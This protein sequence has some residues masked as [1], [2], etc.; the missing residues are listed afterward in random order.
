MARPTKCLDCGA[1]IDW[2]VVR[3]G[4]YWCRACDKAR[5]HRISLGLASLSSRPG[6]ALEKCACVYCKEDDT[7]G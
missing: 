7:D 6:A 1:V 3:L 2:S 4:A 5:V